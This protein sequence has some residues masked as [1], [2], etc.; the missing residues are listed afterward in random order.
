MRKS[1]CILVIILAIGT[2]AY[3]LIA[4]KVNSKKQEEIVLQQEELIANADEATLSS[5]L[6]KALKY[7]QELSN[8]NF[9]NDIEEYNSLLNLSGTGVMGFIEIPCIAGKIAIDHGCDDESLSKGVGH[10]YGTSLP[11]GGQGTHVFLSGHTGMNNQKIFT[12]L[13]QLE[14]GDLFYISAVGN[15]YVYSVEEIRVVD[16][17]SQDVIRTATI[18]ED[19]VTLI[20]CTPYGVNSHRLIVTGKRI[21]LEEQDEEVIKKEDIVVKRSSWEMQYQ[22]AITAGLGVF[23][24]ILAI[25]LGTK[26]IVDVRQARNRKRSNQD[27][28]NLQ[29]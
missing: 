14:I 2:I 7:N 3:P 16:P 21:I 9:E 28:S 17:Y 4:E 11:V 23:A 26:K 24:L 6:A 18:D 12:D 15:S 8:G 19:R 20:T 13:E 25:C 27:S 10:L 1:L 22:K 29:L 5:A